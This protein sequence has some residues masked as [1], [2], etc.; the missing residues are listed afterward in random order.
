M[1]DSQSIKL[2]KCPSCGAPLDPTPG[3]A[4][5]KCPYCGA[6]VV[7]PETLRNS[8]SAQSSKSTDAAAS[9]SD[10]TRLAREGKLEEAA[11]IYSKITGLNAEYAM[12]SV[13]SMAGIRDDEPQ[14]PT[15]PAAP[16]KAPT[17]SPGPFVFT[18]P[19]TSSRP[20]EPFVVDSAPSM[21]VPR[22]RNRS[23]LGG[24]I[25]LIVLIVVISSIFPSILKDLPFKLPTE[26][27]F[28][29]PFFSP[30]SSFIPEPFATETFAFRPRGMSDP[31]PVGVDGNGNIVV[32]D[33]GSKEIQVFDPAGNRT[34]SFTP[35]N[36]PYLTT[37]AVS[38]DGVIY[39]PGRTISMYNLTGEKLG[40]LGTENAFGYDHV[41]LGPG[42][43]VHAVTMEAI[44]RFD[45]NGQINLSIPA[46]TIEELTGDQSN[47]AQ[48]AV[49]AYGNI[50]YWG[51][52]DATIYKFSPEGEYLTQ[53]GGDENPTGSD[54][55]P[56]RF[57]SPHQ[58]VFDNYGRMYV[59][60]F[61]NIQ[62]LDEN[63]NYLDKIEP[64]HYGAVFDAQNNMYAITA[65]DHEVV[66]YTV[67]RP[68]E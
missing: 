18:P 7:I 2:F 1:S 22:R 16:P 55:Q 6:S 65:V 51:T 24:I 38:R 62:V 29:I 53:F 9:L 10:V 3:M 63:G 8:T 47:L 30:G 35:D 13:K 14:R 27:P 60:D 37:L 40:T 44:V 58:I 32:G 12:M 50:Y 45:R 23:C 67:K 5:M 31:R 61:F 42:N 11:R 34:A 49:D 46:E 52:F 4:A 19:Q 41:V 59:V 64:G 17:F 39:V 15:P 48:I 21:P 68:G 43:S 25:N 20:G 57:V 26:F 28:E 33:F 36:D 66:K 54:F 56:G